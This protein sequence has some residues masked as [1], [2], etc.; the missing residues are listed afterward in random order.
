MSQ[1]N[2]SRRHFVAGSLLAGAAASWADPL[3]LP[4]GIQLYTVGADLQKDA[5]GTIKKLAAIGYKEME[6]AGFGSAGTASALRKIFDENGIKCPSAHLNFDLKNL[7]QSFDD[8]HALGCTYATASV[9]RMMIAPPL[10]PYNPAAPP[11]EQ[12]K[13]MQQVM[14]I[15]KAPLTSDELKKLIDAINQ[16]GAAAKQQG[17]LFASHNHTFEFE[18]VD[19]RPALYSL[20]EKTDPA[21]VKFEIDCGWAEVAGYHP[22]DIAKAYPGRVKMLHIKDFSTFGKGDALGPDGP[23]GTEIGAG[24]IDYRKIFASM[25]GQGIEHI[26]VEQE[27]PFS[28]MSPMQA[29]EVDY[30]FLHSLD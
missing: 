14:K 30:R 2:I 6:T 28:N 15:L 4:I 17:L 24:I 12:A 22:G 13:F 25:T 26:F 10:P 11:A 1:H 5:P 8:A 16:V 7:N 29:A 19:G 3:G 18:K 20:I 21:S 23:K 9:P 27:G